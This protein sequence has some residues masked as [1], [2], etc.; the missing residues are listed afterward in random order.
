[1]I[2]TEHIIPFAALI[3]AACNPPPVEPVDVPAPPQA[4][5]FC[6]EYPEAPKC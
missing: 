1:M 2:K 3:L 6:K 4:E 5:Q